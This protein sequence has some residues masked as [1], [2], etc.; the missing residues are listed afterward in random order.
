[1]TGNMKKLLLT[2]P[3]A[4]A[5]LAMADPYAGLS[6]SACEEDANN[7]LF[8]ECRGYGALAGFN[9]DQGMSIELRFDT[10][11][12]DITGINGA[13][14]AKGSYDRDSLGLYARKSFDFDWLITP[15]LTAGVGVS[16]IGYSFEG[17]AD[18]D[19]SYIVLGEGRNESPFFAVGFGLQAPVTE[20]FSFRVGFDYLQHP[21]QTFTANTGGLGG[22]DGFPAEPRT[23]S[24]TSAIRF[25]F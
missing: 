14:A 19:A 24:V 23:Y 3:I 20:Q 21:D 11:E 10:I 22:P 16:Q 5:Q 1:M 18:H 8:S 25:Q 15:D 2:A 4:L 12:A 9:L 7:I 17:P 6:R 13:D